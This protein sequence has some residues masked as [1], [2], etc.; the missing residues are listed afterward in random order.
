MNV[1][2]AI[3][4][5]SAR[6]ITGRLLARQRQKLIDAFHAFR[7]Q[8]PQ[9]SVL[10]VSMADA[11]APMAR[12]AHAIDADAQYVIHWPGS[13]VPLRPAPADPATGQV[14]QHAGGTRLPYADEAFDWVF[15]AE[16]IE[17]V[18]DSERQQELIAELYRVARRGV[19]LTTSNRDHPL[20]FNTGLPLLHWLPSGLWRG[21][22]KAFGARDG[23]PALRLNLLGSKALYHMAAGLPGRPEHDVGHKRVFG[24]KAHY[25][26]MIRKQATAGGQAPLQAQAAS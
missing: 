5:Q 16:T 11:F 12:A 24:I 20:E 6:G 4:A 2:T 13:P 25:F 8:A 21:M 14:R 10:Q 23:T 18:G 15:C 17:H 19:F 1:S 7:A 22:L 9:G 3:G 26:L